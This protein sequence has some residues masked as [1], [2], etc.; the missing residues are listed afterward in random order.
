MRP[1]SQ[2]F[3]IFSLT[4]LMI[5]FTM[6]HLQPSVVHAA[7]AKTKNIVDLLPGDTPVYLKIKEP[8]RL[9]LDELRSPVVLNALKNIPNVGPQLENP[10]IDHVKAVLGVLGSDE[11]LS[12]SELVRDI[13]HGPAEMALV[14]NSKKFVVSVTPKDVARFD[15]LHKKLLEFARQ[16]ATNK[17]N[18]DPVD[19]F[20]HGGINCYSFSPNEAHAIVG[21]RVILASSKQVLEG[22]IDHLNGTKTAEKPL[23]QD[24]HF[25]AA[26]AAAKPDTHDVFGF[27]RYDV[28]RESNA[29]FKPVDEYNPLA[30][31]FFGSWVEAYNQ[32]DWLG[33]VLDVKANK[34]TLEAILPISGEASK[35]DVRKAFTTPDGTV[36]APALK[37]PNQI[38]S[39]TLRRDLSKVWNER[40]LVVRGPGLQNLNGL[41]NGVGQFFGGRDF[42]TG[43][44]GSLKSDWRVVVAEQDEKSLVTK[45]D[46]VLPSFALTVGFDPKDEEFKQR[47]IIAFQSF[48]GVLNVV[49]AQQKASAMVQ[50]QEE[51]GG[52]SFY[53]AR[54]LPPAAPAK[55]EGDAKDE[56]PGVHIRYNFRP[57]LAIN[58][59]HLVIASTTEIAKDV[60]KAMNQP[61]DPADAKNA[62][63]MGLKI[64]GQ[65]LADILDK[66]RERL[67]MQNMVEK[68]HGRKSAETEIG[69]IEALI[70]GLNRGEIAVD[71]T[72]SLFRMRIGFD[73]NPADKK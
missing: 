68:G 28:F 8:A 44:L 3:R 24:E 25:K 34:P 59:D 55:A 15:R 2:K 22:A 47:W 33:L 42:G 37:V 61:T 30:A 12:W 48:V 32:A 49:G 43:V 1:S 4:L 63:S 66:N 21:E 31:I 54:F 69:A 38:G 50:N 17:G 41:D 40:E 39:I 5:S 67:V 70:R 7:D 11:D 72:E 73:L 65:K 9:F 62:H 20:Q 23:S 71:D 64:D 46:L 58:G 35:S 51:I 60:V 56:K 14:T 16:D 19:E 10:Q 18:A 45:P 36:A 57:T 27:V 29:G 52:A 13:F 53:S 6:S 26:V